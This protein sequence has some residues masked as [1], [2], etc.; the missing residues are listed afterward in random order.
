MERHEAETKLAE[1]IEAT[2]KEAPIPFSPRDAE[3]ALSALLATD[4]L[5]E[6]RPIEPCPHAFSL[7][8]LEPIGSRWVVGSDGRK[9][10]V[11]R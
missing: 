8:F 9:V 10:E 1:L 11:D 5:W 2:K 6:G 4:D 7:R 3:R